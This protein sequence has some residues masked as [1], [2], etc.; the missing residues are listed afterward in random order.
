MHGGLDAALERQAH[1]LR[2]IGVP[3]MVLGGIC[4]GA[5]MYFAVAGSAAMAWRLA[6]GILMFGG[7]GV[8]AFRRSLL[9]RYQLAELRRTGALPPPPLHD[10]TVA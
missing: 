10:R 6:M 3:L 7:L 2:T 4:F 5:A 8:V 1:K 9:I